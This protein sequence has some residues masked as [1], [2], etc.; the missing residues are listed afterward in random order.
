MNE[1]MDLRTL[2]LKELNGTLNALNEVVLVLG[3]TSPFSSINLRLFTWK[4]TL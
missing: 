3:K 2:G 4:E 1:F